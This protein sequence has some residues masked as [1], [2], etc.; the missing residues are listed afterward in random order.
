[1]EERERRNFR[2][3]FT[4]QV[5]RSEDDLELDMAALYLAGEEFPSL[6]VRAYHRQLDSLTAEVRD[7]T[8][9]AA[10]ERL[11]ANALNEHLFDQA[12][13]TGKVDNYYSAEGNFLNRVLDTHSGIPVT[14][15]LVYLEIGKRLGI[16]C[17]GVGLPGHFL[18]RLDELDLY[19]DPFKKGQLLSAADCRRLV[20]D[21]MGPHFPWREEYLAPYSKAD[22]LYR[23]L[24]NL[25]TIYLTTGDYPRA[26]ACLERMA[27][28]SPSASHLNRDLCWC[29]A[30][31]SQHQ[32]AIHHLE[33]FLQSTWPSQNATEFKDK[34]ES[35]W[36][37]ITYAKQQSGLQ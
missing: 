20:R 15:S 16:R 2:R 36:S 17:H 32:I 11:V 4:A 35:L 9:G 10:D 1:M 6:D 28:I 24:N 5:Q 18:V 33:L 27:L 26:T 12:G 30:N 3:L 22:I 25:R 31:T 7:T 29:Y 13:F 14:L 19:L 21:V 23:I 37:T 8:D 34:V